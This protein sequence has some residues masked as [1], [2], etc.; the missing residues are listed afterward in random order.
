MLL[1]CWKPSHGSFFYEYR[2]ISFRWRTGPHIGRTPLPLLTLY[3]TTCPTAVS[4]FTGHLTLPWTYTPAFETLQQL[5]L[6]PR[7][8]LSDNHRANSLNRFQALAQT[9]PYW[10]VFKWLYLKLKLQFTYLVCLHYVLS[11]LECKLHKN[12]KEFSNSDHPTLNCS[13]PVALPMLF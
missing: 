5:F 11:L 13:F 8:L 7:L 4:A 12:F 3:S 1:L 2:P 10:G 6:L 9:S